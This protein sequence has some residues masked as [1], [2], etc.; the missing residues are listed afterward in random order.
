MANVLVVVAH[1]DDEALGCGGTIA[2]HVDNDDTVQVMWMITRGLGDSISRSLAALSPGAVQTMGSAKID[3]LLDQQFDVAPLVDLVKSIDDRKKLDPD[4]IYTHWP[5]DLNQDHAL[6]ARAVLTA[7]RPKPAAGPCTILAFETLSSTEWSHGYRAFEP[8][9]YEPLSI[10]QVRNKIKAMECYES[11]MKD[12][13]H[14]RSVQGIMDRAKVRGNECGHM[15][16][17]AFHVIR[18]VG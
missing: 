6:T 1:P 8:N 2:K 9:W 3:S 7:F 17:E 15:Y 14:P 5:H 12:S 11:E 18:R 10:T 4:I 13:P 16:A